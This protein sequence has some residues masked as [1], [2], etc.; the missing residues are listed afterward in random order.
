MPNEWIAFSLSFAA[1][2]VLICAAVTTVNLVIDPFGVSLIQVVT[3]YNEVKIA[4][5]ENDRSVKPFAPLK[6]QPRTVIMGTSRVKQAFDPRLL[7][8]TEYF[9]AYN[10]GID[11][12]LL[13]ELRQ[14]LEAYLKLGIPIRHLFLELFPFQFPHWADSEAGIGLPHSYNDLFERYVGLTLSLRSLQRSIETIDANLRPDRWPRSPS[15]YDEFGYAGWRGGASGDYFPK[16]PVIS[17]TSYDSQVVLKSSAF[18][19][20]DEIIRLCDEHGI[21]LRMFIAP[22][23]PTALYPEWATSNFYRVW[24]ERLSAYGRVN[25]FLTV[26]EFRERE[27]GRY[28]TYWIDPSHISRA[29]AERIL[30]DLTRVDGPR[31]AVTLTPDS[32]PSVLAK[33]EDDLAHWAEFNPAFV[34]EFRKAA[35][36]AIL[37]K[38]ST[39]FVQAPEVIDIANDYDSDL[40]I[41]SPRGADLPDIL[42]CFYGDCSIQL[43]A[44]FSNQTPGSPAF[45]I[46]QY[47]ST[48]GGWQLLQTD[49]QLILQRD[50][51]AAQIAG[52]W[53]PE[54]G[55]WH[56]IEIVKK[57]KVIELLV[58]GE[59]IVE[60]ATQLF[61]DDGVISNFKFY[62]GVRPPPMPIPFYGRIKDIQ[63]RRSAPVG[64]VKMSHAL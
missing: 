46:G 2:V 8:G 11:G 15:Y 14:L 50:G 3:P 5:L 62:A 13:S 44:Q 56:R 20:L 23:H 10:A 57:D 27:I 59:Q 21:E 51:G 33:L 39:S 64:G 47:S 53:T 63:I 9:P 52:S 37:P 17:R 32:L 1:G 6:V 55:K 18:S 12:G 22:L 38:A 34:A 24:L 49:T 41:A 29:A 4:R 30:S 7:E 48:L 40:H 54:L 42:P 43:K 31:E 26:A 61:S 28:K 60:S 45:M 19:D 35:P 16:H 25:S 36:G 58:D